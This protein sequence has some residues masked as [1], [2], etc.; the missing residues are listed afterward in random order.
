MHERGLG[1]DVEHVVNVIVLMRWLKDA[2]AF[3][4]MVKGLCVICLE[5][6]RCY[7]CCC[8]GGFYCSVACQHADWALSHKSVCPWRA[9]VRCFREGGLLN[10]DVVRVI[11]R[12][13]TN[14]KRGTWGSIPVWL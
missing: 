7:R 2:K 13:L 12:F 1:R 11:Q 3:G 9:V 10:A 5:Y 14:S 6:A 4:S 8:G